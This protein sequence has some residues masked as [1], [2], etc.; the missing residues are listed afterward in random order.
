M[1]PNSKRYLPIVIL[2][3]VV[4]GGVYMTR[5]G[6]LAGE[7]GMAGLDAHLAHLGKV[8]QEI[9][10]QLDALVVRPAL[11][12][13][14]TDDRVEI[15]RARDAIV[16]RGIPALAS[17]TT[18]LHE[19]GCFQP[20]SA[21]EVRAIVKILERAEVTPVQRRVVAWVL[22]D[23]AAHAARDLQFETPKVKPF[24]SNPAIAR[25]V[26]ELRT[27]NLDVEIPSPGPTIDPNAIIWDC[28]Y[29]ALSGVSH[30]LR[31]GVVDANTLHTKALDGLAGL[32]K[33]HPVAPGLVRVATLAASAAKKPASTYLEIVGRQDLG[34]EARAV[35][36]RAAVA[37]KVDLSQLK[38]SIGAAPPRP[39]A[40]C[41]VVAG[42]PDSLKVAGQ[43]KDYD[44]RTAAIA[45]AP[46]ASDATAIKAALEAAALPEIS[47][48]EREER[49]ASI[50]VAATKCSDPAACLASVDT[51]APQHPELKLPAQIAGVLHA[52]NPKRPTIESAPEA[53]EVELSAMLGQI[54][55]AEGTVQVSAKLG[56]LS[57]VPAIAAGGPNGIA[58]ADT[59]PTLTFSLP[60]DD[61][62]CDFV[63]NPGSAQPAV[64]EAFEN[65]E[66]GVVC[67]KPGRYTG[68]LVLSKA[69]VRL[70]AL[71]EGVVLEGPIVVEAPVTLIG[72][73][74]EGPVAVAETA[75]GA[76]FASN[77]F[78]RGG[79]SLTA[80]LS[81]AG[82]EN[83][84][85][86]TFKVPGGALPVALSG[87]AIR[88]PGQ[89]QQKAAV[90]QEAIALA[91]GWPP[92]LD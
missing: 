52:L 88:L 12:R 32:A 15:E 13:V 81:L 34:D 29:M 59:K 23:A 87:V 69:N 55:R 68:P 45:R 67:A 86:K 39:L 2:A 9:M 14:Q 37:E 72:F 40:E 82:N 17:L 50:A 74:V 30:A 70:Q 80:Q 16:A 77:K 62:G 5:G 25:A 92:R 48:R 89:D 54:A 20:G 60:R 61:A 28:T 21:T 49:I 76:A 11:P 19:N 53:N 10:N 63:I 85:G 3:A 71:R 26:D 4:A 58:A 44:L 56:A 84:A 57:S 31:S 22:L 24:S 78:E 65:L 83:G 51:L 66:T 42:D 90:N 73:T 79:V 27:G 18:H 35:G 8:D 75:R 7:A 46:V 38:T 36:C 33:D 1:N 41:L 6:R 91:A 64:D 43:S 47:P